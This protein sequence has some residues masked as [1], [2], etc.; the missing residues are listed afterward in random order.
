MM[1]SI[2]TSAALQQFSYFHLSTGVKEMRRTTLADGGTKIYFSSSYT[3]LY[4]D[5][6]KSTTKCYHF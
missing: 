1:V 5:I 2:P 3:P 6:K 4:K